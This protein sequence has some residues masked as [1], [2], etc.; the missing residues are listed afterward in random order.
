MSNLPLRNAVLYVQGYEGVLIQR[1]GRG[2]IG[3]V[4]LVTIRTVVTDRYKPKGD[5]VID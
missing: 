1:R 2:K 5:E 4:H 3:D